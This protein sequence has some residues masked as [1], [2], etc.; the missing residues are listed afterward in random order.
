L[1]PAN[2]LYKEYKPFSL[3]PTGIGQPFVTR[4]RL[5]PAKSPG[6]SDT[7]DPLRVIDLDTVM[8]GLV[9]HDFGDLARSSIGNHAET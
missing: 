7:G 1:L 9:A 2:K 3:K 4:R 8:A 6:C 5:E